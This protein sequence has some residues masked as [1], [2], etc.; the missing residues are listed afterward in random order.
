MA[1]TVPSKAN[2]GDPNE[3]IEVAVVTENGLSS[4]SEFYARTILRDY[5]CKN[6][7]IIVDNLH[8]KLNPGLSENSRAAIVVDGVGS[9]LSS[10]ISVLEGIGIRGDRKI[11]ASVYPDNSYEGV[12]GCVPLKSSIV[13]SLGD[14]IKELEDVLL[15]IG[16]DLCAEEWERSDNLRRMRMMQERSRASD[17]EIQA[18]QPA[19]AALPTDS[20]PKGRFQRLFNLLKAFLI[21]IRSKLN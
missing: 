3:P 15:K 13:S 2:L 16:R 4:T 12:P 21:K 8:F 11:L 7:E 14:G 17:E 9:K 18:R 1:S 19:V 5:D 6:N 20:V 10:L